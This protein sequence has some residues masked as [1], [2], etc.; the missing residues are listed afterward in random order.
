[1]EMDE[2]AFG[3][4]RME[5]GIRYGN[6]VEGTGLFPARRNLSGMWGLMFSAVFFPAMFL[7]RCTSE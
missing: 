3:G 6:C 2:W 1:M 5:E 4:S 7:R